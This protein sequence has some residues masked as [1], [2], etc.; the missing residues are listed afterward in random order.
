M[1]ASVSYYTFLLLIIIFYL[2]LFF[3]N[4]KRSPKK[5]RV[6]IN[7][8][9]LLG[10]IKNSFIFFMSLL[11]FQINIILA[12]YLVFLDMIYIPG[13]LM[14][15]TYIFLRSDDRPFKFV[16]KKILLIS[17]SLVCIILLF[18][19][20]YK[21]TVEYGYTLGMYNNILFRSIYIIIFLIFLV[22]SILTKLN[23]STNIDGLN[24]IAVTMC[25]FIFE[26]L[27]LLSFSKYIPYCL[28]GELFL[29]IT[30]TYSLKTFKS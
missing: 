17:M 21:L 13:I 28:V 29:G 12:K 5:V 27:V 7:T 26:N 23:K 30:L 16:E 2:Y 25:I 8:F 18:Q 14:V 22:K 4:C 3:E 6:Y 24:L 20:V 19:P 9:L 15:L 10:I 1:I 11:T